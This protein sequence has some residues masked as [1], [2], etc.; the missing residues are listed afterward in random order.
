MICDSEGHVYTCPIYMPRLNQ[1]L[2][3]S[4]FACDMVLPFTGFL[5][6]SQ[7][8]MLRL[9]CWRRRVLPSGVS[10]SVLCALP[11]ACMA[12]CR[13]CTRNIRI[14][15]MPVT[16]RRM[17]RVNST[18]RAPDMTSTGYSFMLHCTCIDL[19]STQI[20]NAFV[21]ADLA[22]LCCL[23]YSSLAHKRDF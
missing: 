14:L 1:V 21:C 22:F 18:A 19:V 9:R 17:V 10:R 6:S 8:C 11:G 16:S 3:T 20:S 13:H 12:C 7:L 23:Q 15:P 4:F 2:T 5:S